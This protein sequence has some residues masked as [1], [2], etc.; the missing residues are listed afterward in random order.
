MRSSDLIKFNVSGFV[1][2]NA[3]NYKRYIQIESNHKCNEIST[4]EILYVK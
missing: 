3:T 1:H 4:G 2:D